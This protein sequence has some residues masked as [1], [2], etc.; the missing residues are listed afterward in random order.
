MLSRVVMGCYGGKSIK[1]FLAWQ[2]RQPLGN[3]PSFA[4]SGAARCKPQPPAQHDLD[5]RSLLMQ[6]PPND[7]SPNQVFYLILTKSLLYESI[8]LIRNLPPMLSWYA[9]WPLELD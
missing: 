1:P 9:L 6:A 7:E 4:P 5:E 3:K 2:A 8:L